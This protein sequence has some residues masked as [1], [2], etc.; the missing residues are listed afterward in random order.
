ME[1]CENCHTA[2][3]VAKDCPH[4]LSKSIIDRLMVYQIARRKYSES[5]QFRALFDLCSERAQTAS[6]L[7][8]SFKDSEII[9]LATIATQPVI[10]P[11][12]TTDEPAN[13]RRLEESQKAADVL[14]E[15]AKKI[16]DL[17]V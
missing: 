6:R 14:F 16:E 5:E 8:R 9:S 12:S 13:R 1:V 10:L 2:F 3:H 7:S 15:M 4:Q 11:W 17:S